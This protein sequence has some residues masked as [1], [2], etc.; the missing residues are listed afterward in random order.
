[1]SK[2]DDLAAKYAAELQKLGMTA[3]ADLLM[4]AIKACGPSIYSA[5]AETVAGSDPG[6]LARVRTNFMAKRLGMTD[7]TQATA[8][9]DK[10]LDT[11]V[12]KAQLQ[13]I[14][15]ASKLEEYIKAYSEVRAKANEDG[16]ITANEQA[17]LDAELKR[18][19]G[20]MDSVK[21]D[22]RDFSKDFGSPKTF[23]FKSGL[24]EGLNAAFNGGDPLQV[25]RQRLAEG[26]RSSII[27]GAMAQRYM[28][29]IQPYLDELGSALAAGLDPAQAVQKLG[30]ILPTISVQMQT[31][32]GPLFNMLNSVLP[33]A[34]ADNTAATRENTAATKEA[35][36]QQTT[37]VN[38]AD[39]GR[40]PDFRTRLGGM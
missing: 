37:I 40:R 33:G 34:L 11:W 20:E 23:D 10:A 31:E 22:F 38:Y 32:L 4:A 8:A 7:E 15:A 18:I 35:Q 29:Q 19:R 6:E 28:A 39:T 30:G 36:F 25:M 17:Q 16:T 12:V 13:I 14:M 21:N 5:D 1:M 2:R 26:I 3:D 24:T 9:L 27:E